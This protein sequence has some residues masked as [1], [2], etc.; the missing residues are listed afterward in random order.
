MRFISSADCFFGEDRYQQFAQFHSGAFR[1]VGVLL[2][3][4]ALTDHE[5]LAYLIH[6]LEGEGVNAGNLV[7]IPITREPTY[8]DL[9][10]LAETMR[11]LSPDY[12]FAVGGGS[13]LDLAKGVALLLNN[14]GK[15]VEFRGMGLVRNPPRPLTVVPTTAGTGSEVTWTASFI[16]DDSGLKLGING[17]NVFPTASILEPR[18]LVGSPR[19]VAL[20]AGLDALVHAVEAISSPMATSVT[21]PIAAKAARLMMEGLPAVVQDP[22]SPSLWD[23]VQLGAFLAGLAMLN[24]SGGPASGVSYP[25]GVHYRVPHGYAGGVVLPHVVRFNVDHGYSG[26]SLL[27]EASPARVGQSDL[28][29]SEGFADELEALMVTLDAPRDFARWGTDVEGTVD[30]LVQD[31]LVNRAANLKLNPIHFGEPELRGLLESVCSLKS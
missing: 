19:D 4:A 27:S 31:T 17:P 12:I 8:G 26:Y 2:V 6:C 30:F 9:D 14:P 11:D 1:G 29:L 13:L 18:L 15:G 21:D 5:G 10:D 16:D 20:G 3:D 23:K 25:I 28:E 7:A 22:G 24:S